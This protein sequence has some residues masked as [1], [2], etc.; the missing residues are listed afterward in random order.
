MPQ[1]S[2]QR[3]RQQF[4]VDLYTPGDLMKAKSLVK[5]FEFYA[6]QA[7]RLWAASEQLMSRSRARK[8]NVRESGSCHYCGAHGHH[9][10]SCWLKI[11]NKDVCFGCGERGHIFRDCPRRITPKDPPLPLSSDECNEGVRQ[12]LL[13]LERKLQ[14]EQHE[15]T[16]PRMRRGG[17]RS[18]GAWHKNDT[19][20]SC[21]VVEESLISASRRCEATSSARLTEDTEGSSG[22]WHP[23]SSSSELRVEMSVVDVSVHT[24]PSAESPTSASGSDTTTNVT[25]DWSDP[26][27]LDPSRL[28]DEAESNA[29]TSLPTHSAASSPSTIF[30]H[31]IPVDELQPCLG[32]G[33]G[34]DCDDEEGEEEED[35]D[36]DIGVDVGVGLEINERLEGDAASEG[37]RT[38]S[39]SFEYIS[40]VDGC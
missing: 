40:S 38:Q 30:A 25:H 27:L 7:D 24:E 20:Y 2:K 35:D 37:N 14:G 34:D 4:N 16:K 13:E 19:V 5:E 18:R 39:D 15:A 29:S 23:S 32:E 22:H 21:D 3:G 26:R 17:R 31:I 28:F 11:V 12:K 1:R 33:A 10:K 6:R 9:S 8:A 36:T